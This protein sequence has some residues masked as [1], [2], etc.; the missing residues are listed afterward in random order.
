VS[1]YTNQAAILGEIQMADLISLTDDD[2]TGQLNTTVLNQVITNASGIVD[3]YCANLYG[4]QLPFNPV[5]SSVASMALVIACYS[6]YRRREVPYEKN[7]FAPQYKEAIDF[8]KMVNTGDMHLNDVPFRDFPQV[9]VAAR[10]NGGIYGV[11]GSN[12]PY[13]SM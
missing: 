13:T 4:T 11:Q 12:Q 5:P 1:T 3:R 6:L 9:G 10:C 2:S 8:L 7:N